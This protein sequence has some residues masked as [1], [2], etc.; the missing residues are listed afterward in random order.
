MTYNVLLLFIRR[1]GSHV[2]RALLTLQL[3]V[4]LAAEAP[5]LAVEVPAQAPSSVVVV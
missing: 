4:A 1:I 5:A 2:L 3:L